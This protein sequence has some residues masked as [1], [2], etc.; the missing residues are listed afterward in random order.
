MEGPGDGP[1]D[2]DAMPLYE[3]RCATCGAHEEKLQGFS[4]PAEH[5]CPNCQAQA[6][7]K[8][9]LSR[10]AFTLAG[11]GW[12]ASGYAEGGSGAKAE[13]PKTEAPA[14]APSAT[15]SSSGGCSGGCACH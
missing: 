5:D 11:G 15:G 7:M 13:A 10:T 12:Y 1:M 9:Q 8:R 14:S 3:Y 4:A 6:G 2:E